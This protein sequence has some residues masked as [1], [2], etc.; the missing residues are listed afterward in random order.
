VTRAELIETLWSGNY[1]VGEQALNRVVSETR[2]AAKS[3][4]AAP[5]IETVQKTGYRVSGLDPQPGSR[6][7]FAWPT[8]ARLV[9]ALA[10]FVVVMAAIS[11]VI[12]N[13]M[14]LVWMQSHAN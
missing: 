6:A 12:D 10:I 8:T 2:R 11:V 3:V 4:A 1:L 9:I 13:A 5:L 7:R 14:G